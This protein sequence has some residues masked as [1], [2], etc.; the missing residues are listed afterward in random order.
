MESWEKRLTVKNLRLNERFRAGELIVL[1]H[2]RPKDSLEGWVLA[3]QPVF[4]IESDALQQVVM[5]DG[6]K[7]MMFVNTVELVELP[8]RVI[9]TLIRF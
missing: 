4:P 3:Y 2:F 5:A 9:P 6:D 1:L 8:E 7:K